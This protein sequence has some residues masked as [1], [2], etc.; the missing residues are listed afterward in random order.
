MVASF[1][2]GRRG[3]RAGAW[4]RARGRLGS[5]ARGL[6]EREQPAAVSPQVF[7]E[8]A[9]LERVMGD[10]EVAGAIIGAFLED[11]PEQLTGLQSSLSRGTM[12]PPCS[13]STGSAERP[14]PSA[15]S[16]CNARRW[17]RK[18]TAGPETSALWRRSFAN[19][20]SSFRRLGTPWND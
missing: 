20:S 10:R 16:R 4:L 19:C 7:D 3:P 14:R 18:R 8:A 11:V 15:E 5:E 2:A 13:R 9:L 12:L 6:G 17:Q 1:G